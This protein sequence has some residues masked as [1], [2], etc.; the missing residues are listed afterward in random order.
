MLFIT[1]KNGLTITSSLKALSVHLKFC[2][3]RVNLFGKETAIINL[4]DAEVNFYGKCSLMLPLVHSADKNVEAVVTD[5]LVSKQLHLRPPLQNSVF[6]NSYTN[7][8]F[9]H[10]RKRPGPGTNTFSASRKC[11]LTRA[12]TV[13]QETIATTIFKAIV[14]TIRNNVAKNKKVAKFPV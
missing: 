13:L 7:P 3:S 6:L 10:S 12:Y 5:T 2:S 8:V 9:L 1:E 4:D 11:P 14:V